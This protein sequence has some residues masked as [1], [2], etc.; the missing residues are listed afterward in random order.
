MITNYQVMKILSFDEERK[1]INLVLKDQTGRENTSKK[2][3]FILL[4]VRNLAA[5]EPV[6]FFQWL[7]K[8]AKTPGFCWIQGIIP[9]SRRTL[10]GFLYENQDLHGSFGTLVEHE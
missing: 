2:I 1:V 4:D 9:S 3:S 5:Q 8:T 7:K 6:D 10:E